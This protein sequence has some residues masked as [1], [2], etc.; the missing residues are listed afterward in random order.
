VRL[1]HLAA[2]EAERDERRVGQR[3]RLV[4]VELV[5][6]RRCP[7]RSASRCTDRWGCPYCVSFMLIPPARAS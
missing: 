1:A 3:D 7:C 4:R 5:L 6:T 2:R